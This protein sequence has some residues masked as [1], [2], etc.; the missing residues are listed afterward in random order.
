LIWLVTCKSYFHSL[1]GQSSFY[2]LNKLAEQDKKRPC[3]YSEEA[4]PNRDFKFSPY[5]GPEINEDDRR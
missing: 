3:K 4:R 2:I 1:Q 5:C